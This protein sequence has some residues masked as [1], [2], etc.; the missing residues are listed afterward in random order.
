MEVY[1][2]MI[3]IMVMIVICARN[4]ETKELVVMKYMERGHK[5]VVLTPTHLA[6]VMEYA[7]GGELF[8]RTLQCWSASWPGTS[9]SNSFLELITVLP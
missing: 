7:A 1:L 6:I 4:K 8:E 9:F 3:M 2:I 5:E